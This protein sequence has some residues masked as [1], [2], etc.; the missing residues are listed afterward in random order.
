MLGTSGNL[1]ILIQQ[2][3]I[4]L[5][6]TASGKHKGE[7]TED[8]FIL[9][10][11]EGQPQGTA[12]TDQKPSDETLLHGTIYKH[13][14]AKAVFHVHTTNSTLVSMR[15]AERGMQNIE[16]TGLEM[17]KGLGF[18]THDVKIN[19]PVIENSQDMKYLASIVPSHI[20]E[21][22]PGFLLRGHRVYAWGQSPHEAKRHVEIFE[23]LFEYRIKE[24]SIT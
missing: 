18:K 2:E 21:E 4:H 14:D 19:I 15:N 3:P 1:S 7:L 24:L 6:I 23:F 5:L 22:V 9:V 8:D 12:P 10:D 16:F 20:N 13:T 17:L 11:E